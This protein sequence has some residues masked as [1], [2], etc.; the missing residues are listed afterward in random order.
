MS[1]DIL[2][3]VV[4]PVYNC[5]RYLAEAIESILAQMSAGRHHRDR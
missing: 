3:S 1:K 2:I 4:I 5:E